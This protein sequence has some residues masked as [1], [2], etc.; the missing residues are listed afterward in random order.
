MSFSDFIIH[1]RAELILIAIT[2]ITTS[3]LIL[4]VIGRDKFRWFASEML[5]LYSGEKSYFS[6]KRIESGIAFIIGE[7]GAIFW[8]QHSYEKMDT[9]D[10]CMWLTIQLAVAG[11]M[12]SAI[13]KEKKVTPDGQQSS[14]G[15]N[16]E[17]PNGNGQ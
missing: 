7:A 12:V 11:W 13:Q 5:K 16:G 6:K 3:V 1:F 4:F 17:S 15:N 10:F 14:G 8:I 9:Y 2:A